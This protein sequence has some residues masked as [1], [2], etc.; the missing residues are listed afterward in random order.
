MVVET[1]LTLQNDRK[2]GFSEICK[3]IIQIQQS[4]VP[5][6]MHFSDIWEP[7]MVKF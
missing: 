3:Q 5:P 6:K 1:W 7:Y 4:E 2:I